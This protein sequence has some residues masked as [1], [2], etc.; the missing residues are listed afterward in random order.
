MKYI[1]LLLYLPFYY[2]FAGNEVGNGGDVIV[3]NGRVELLDYFEAKSLNFSLP[4]VSKKK[5][6]Q[7]IIREILNDFSKI[8][9]KL[10]SQY[11]QRLS[12]I[13]KQIEYR[14][15]I[16]LT[17]IPDS[18]NEMLP[19]ECELKQIAIRRKKEINGKLFLI[20]KDLWEQLSSLH[21]AGL[22]LHEII[23][24][25]FFYLGEKNSRKARYMN[26]LLAHIGSNGK[27]L[28]SYKKILQ[29]ETIPIYR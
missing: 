13:Y 25:H 1:F 12:E 3:C 15:N 23:Y 29:S 5:G 27:L 26:A 17:D 11:F 20:S 21:K 4:K 16:I 18:N 8:D 2:S 6:H 19:R 9:K 28:M 10:A 14:S 24:E 7:L 22:I